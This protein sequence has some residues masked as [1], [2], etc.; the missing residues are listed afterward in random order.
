M[1]QQMLTASDRGGE[2]AAPAAVRETVAAVARRHGVPSAAVRPVPVAGEAAYTWYLGDGLVAKV[3]R[4]S[5]G[6]V[7]DLRKEAVVIPYAARLGVR[8]PEIVEDGGAADVPYLL[9]RR[10]RGTVPGGGEPS[11]AVHRALGR[12]L[13][14]LHGAGPPA[15]ALPG[16]P[17]ED[18]AGDPR[19]GVDRSAAEGW[20]GPGP[21]RWL[22]DWCDRLT[23]L[24]AQAVVRP[25]LIHGDVSALN[26]LV[27]APAD[28]GAVTLVDWGDAAVTDPAVE[29]A[30]VPPRSLGDVF[31]GYGVPPGEAGVWWARV[32]LLHLSWAVARLGDGPRPGAPHWSAQPGN[33]LLELLRLFADPDGG[34]PAVPDA[35]RPVPVR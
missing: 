28:G 13:A 14:L 4:R 32:L 5:P 10:I 7:A 35:V 20:I 29:F 21:A 1:R 25:V 26:I 18:V 24:A 17:V 23:G 8:V 31:T 34:A 9:L 6:P 19:P 30:K 12:E 3:A 11:P 16:V 22:G 2:E 27:D 15:S 33:R